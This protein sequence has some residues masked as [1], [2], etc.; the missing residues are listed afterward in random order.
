MREQIANAERILIK[1]GTKVLTNQDGRIATDRLSSLV[2]QCARLVK[3]EGKQLILVSSGAVGM[4][5]SALGMA[6]VKDLPAKQACAAVGQ[7]LL[8]KEYQGLFAEHDLMTGQILVTADDFSHRQRY[9]NLHDTFE[10]LL[11]CGVIPVANENDTVSTM[12]LQEDSRTHSFGDNDLLSALIASKL[13]VD[14]LLILTDVD[15]IYDDNPKKDPDAQ[16][17]EEIDDFDKI[18]KLGLRGQS[19]YGRGGVSSKIEAVRL[20]S[21]GGVSTVIASGFK[22]DAILNCKGTFVG[23]R[24][25]LGDRK[26]WI[27]F[28]SGFEGVLVINSGAAEALIEKKA[29]LLPTG[30]LSVR[31]SFSAEEVVRVETEDGRELGRGI[32]YFSSDQIA[33]IRGLHSSEISKKLGSASHEE[34]IHRDHLVVFGEAI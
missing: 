10:Y 22:Q 21:L 18:T 11:S 23:P 28:S 5:R 29:S 15:G 17:I 20:A 27:G 1:L 12:E 8:M 32:T 25:K 14:L 34:V 31:G 3:K 33:Q 9:L 6:K 30:I 4:G 13:G 26:R 24:L 16:V 19:V 7:I 2:A